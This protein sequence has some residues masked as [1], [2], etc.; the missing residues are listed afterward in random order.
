MLSRGPQR[1]F[2]GPKLEKL[3]A[4]LK[5]AEH[6]NGV[7]TST[8]SRRYIQGFPRPPRFAVEGAS[9]TNAE[10]QNGGF[11]DTTV[12]L[13]NASPTSLHPA[14]DW[15]AGG[16]GIGR[17]VWGSSQST[18]NEDPGKV[19]QQPR[20]GAVGGTDQCER[21][22]KF[23]MLRTLADVAKLMLL[24][25]ADGDGRGAAAWQCVWQE[26]EPTI[27]LDECSSL[28]NGAIFAASRPPRR[29]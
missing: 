26:E 17:L 15:G 2:P 19:P 18:A 23:C 14:W 22:A 9:Q 12:G 29:R 3:K 25:L 27:L 20:D 7:H 10:S 6:D 8:A 28:D 5:K 4:K 11:L 13:C 24:M 21:F 16:G 1:F